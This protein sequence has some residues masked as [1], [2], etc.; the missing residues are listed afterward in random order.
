MQ[1]NKVAKTD[2][3]TLGVC[4]TKVSNGMQELLS[5]HVRKMMLG[6]DKDK[7]VQVIKNI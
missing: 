6:Q 3:V 5:I 4:S 1:T 2:L 7:V